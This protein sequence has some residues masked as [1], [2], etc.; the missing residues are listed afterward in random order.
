MVNRCPSA[1][2]VISN[3]NLFDQFVDKITTE[4]RY[5]KQITVLYRIETVTTQSGDRQ[6]GDK[7]KNGDKVKWRH[8][9]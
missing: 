2:H 9:V 7:Y 8:D 5:N 6:N 3:M 1:V 4:S